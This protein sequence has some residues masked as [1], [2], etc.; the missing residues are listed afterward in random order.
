M[1]KSKKN[2]VIGLMAVCSLS[3]GVFAANR[4]N[5]DVASAE[6]TTVTD[7]TDSFT[8]KTLSKEWTVLGQT[9][10]DA[11]IVDVAYNAMIFAADFNTYQTQVCY[12]E[13]EMTGPCKVE[14]TTL[15]ES[16]SSGWMAFSV[17]SPS[18]SIGMPYACAAFIMAPTYT[19]IFARDGQFIAVQEEYMQVFSPVMEKYEGEL[20]KTTFDF[21]ETDVDDYYDV[22]Y[23]VETMDGEQIGSYVYQ[24]V[25]ITSGY[26]GL[27][28]NYCRLGVVSFKIF[29]GD[30]EKVDVDMSNTAIRYPTTG[31]LASEWVAATEFDSTTLKMGV[32]ASLDVSKAG[33]SVVY[34][35]QYTR[36]LTTE[37]EELYSLSADVNTS[38][39]G[40][41][42]ATGFEIGKATAETQGTFVGLTKD[43]GG[44][45]YL[46][47]FD[48][49]NQKKVAVDAVA[50]DGATMQLVTYYDNT[51]TL[52]L[53]NTSL[54]F[55]CDTVEGYFALT[56]ADF[57]D[58]FEGQNGAKLD[59]FVYTLNSYQNVQ[60]KDLGINFEGTKTTYY[61]AIDA[62]ATD[63]YIHKKDW[64]IADDVIVPMY[65]GEVD[66]NTVTF[67]GLNYSSYFGPTAK[68]TNFI[69]RFDISFFDDV[70][71]ISQPIIGLQYGMED[72]DATVAESYFLGVQSFI[73]K[74]YV[75]SQSAK[76]T[77]GAGVVPLCSDPYGVNHE[78]IFKKNTTYNVMY[79]A[80][81][82]SVKLYLK[83]DSQADSMFEILR[84]EVRDV[85]TQGYLQVYAMNNAQFDLD[86]FS[87]VN[88]DYNMLSTEYEGNG[89]EVL[90]SDF[91]MGDTL[92]GFT[93]QNA[94]YEDTS[95]LIKE[96]GYILSDETIKNNIFRFK[97]KATTGDV[98]V[99]HGELKITVSASGD[100]IF[101]V[102]NKKIREFALDEKIDFEGAVFEIYKMGNSLMISYVN[103]DQ[104]VS[105]I[106]NYQYEIVADNLFEDE[107][108]L[109]ADGG[110]LEIYSLALFDLKPTRTIAT[111]NYDAAIDYVD[112]WTV[113][114][115]IQELNGEST[116]ESGCGS[117]VASGMVILPIT[118]AFVGTFVLRRRKDEKNQ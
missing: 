78:N 11:E 19:H 51:A 89:Y 25:F 38:D 81:N 104:P 115:S 52:T 13:Y 32:I 108:K 87:V 113:K 54:S 40:V 56:T 63:Y 67:S 88:L 34:N 17:G 50:V 9:D 33:T 73:Q 35:T 12:K 8:D 95:L 66:N 86:N 2:I 64:R 75:V 47:A 27:N 44:T 77:T 85:N 92:E 116:E 55:R 5:T 37:L 68:Y 93:L 48:G 91:S 20:I 102:H 29:E 15:S 62:E 4:L 111:R 107:I 31:S 1:K 22:V 18:P 71:A 69:V 58:C 114:T 30:E 101:I 79:V 7:Y 90:R 14:F 60:S 103:G 84:A 57:Y 23:T 39:M 98:V 28:A 118:C 72:T 97:T 112:P 59:N 110:D 42:V 100:N 49:L 16:F 70:D 41:G 24:D 106:K 65:F 83:E 26:F 109:Y 43:D 45:Y 3:A 61:E 76:L 10:S 82:G 6:V 94:K 99:E 74:T 36:P 80:Q 96:G 53:G 105:C 46:V 117:S 21:Q